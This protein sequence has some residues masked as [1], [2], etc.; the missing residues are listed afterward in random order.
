MP[1]EHTLAA[2]RACV[3]ACQG[4]MLYRDATQAVFGEG[5]AHARVMLIGEQPGDSEDLAGKPFVGPA[6]RL[7]D[8][9]L[10]EAGIPRDEAYVTN[11]IKHFKYTRRG[12]RRIHDKPTRYEIEACK[13]WLLGEL[14]AVAPDIVVVLGATAAQ[15]LLG[16]TFRV[17]K[18]RGIDHATPLAR[19]TFATVHPASVL[20]APDEEQRHQAREDFFADLRVVGDCYRRLGARR[21][22]AEARPEVRPGARARA[23][24][25]RV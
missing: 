16:S 19:H 12:K 17:T 11:V 15:A 10:A 13:P 18:E 9:G 2:M 21:E 1:A 23:R 14:E 8:Q 3:P 4:C 22:P 7:L 5:S 24:S 6:G 20:R 25:A